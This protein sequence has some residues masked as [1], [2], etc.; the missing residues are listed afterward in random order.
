MKN[1]LTIINRRRFLIRAAEMGALIIATP[2]TIA[3]VTDA[4][5]KLKIHPTSP[6]ALGP[7]YKRNAPNRS[8]L[9]AAGDPGPPL[10]LSGKVYSEKGNLLPNAKLEI[11]QTDANGIYDTVGN[12]Y[13]AKLIAGPEGNYSLESVMPGHY[14]ARV[15]QHVHYLIHAEGHKP[16]VTEL[17]FATDPVFEGDPDK[18]YHRDPV[19]TN[20]ELIRPV[21]ITGKPKSITAEVKFNLVLEA[22]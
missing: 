19:I 21:T 5:T 20:R 6:N 14:P 16:L 15:C 10:K 11:W 2:V 8:I 22:L 3:S 1:K 18:N 12:R 7:F 17:N 9:R 13:R 4:F